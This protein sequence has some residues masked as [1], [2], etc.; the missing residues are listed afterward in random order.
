[1]IVTPLVILPH[2]FQM[3][4]AGFFLVGIGIAAVIAVFAASKQADALI[5]D[6]LSQPSRDE[7]QPQ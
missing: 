7:G 6:V 1:M 2:Y 3:H 5:D 4:T